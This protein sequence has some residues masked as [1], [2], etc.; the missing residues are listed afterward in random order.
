MTLCIYIDIDIEDGHHKF[1]LCSSIMLVIFSLISLV[2]IIAL[3]LYSIGP[4]Q[5]I[6][7]TFRRYRII[8]ETL[9]AACNLLFVTGYYINDN[10]CGGEYQWNFGAICTCLSWI[11]VIISLK[12]IPSIAANINKLFTI[13]KQFVKISFLPILLLITFFLPFLMLFTA[14]WPVSIC[15]TLLYIL[16]YSST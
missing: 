6:S 10:W 16:K 2:I 15:F 4:K 3:T 9:L 8:F 13:I 12:G 1:L 7:L 14:P 11:T 5:I